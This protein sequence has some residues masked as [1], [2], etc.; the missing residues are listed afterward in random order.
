MQH[1]FLCLFVSIPFE[2]I[3]QYASIWATE[4]KLPA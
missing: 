2:T 1:M 3:G 4:L